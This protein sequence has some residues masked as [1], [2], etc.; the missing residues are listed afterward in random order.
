M[1]RIWFFLSMFV[2]LT[3]VLVG[4]RNKKGQ[5]FDEFLAEKYPYIEYRNSSYNFDSKNEKIDIIDGYYLNQGNSYE[6]VATDNGYD[7]VIHFEKGGEG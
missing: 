6:W 2:I 3:L 7:L 1:K 4:C 5:T